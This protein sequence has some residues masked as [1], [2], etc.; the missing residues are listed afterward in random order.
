V[1]VGDVVGVLEVALGTPGYAS[2]QNKLGGKHSAHQHQRNP[3]HLPAISYTSPFKVMRMMCWNAFR[4]RLHDVR[5]H[6]SGCC[7][8]MATRNSRGLQHGN[9]S[10]RVTKLSNLSSH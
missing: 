3:I 6:T 8:H 4:Y 7:L 5:L 10:D 9:S 2:D 1:D